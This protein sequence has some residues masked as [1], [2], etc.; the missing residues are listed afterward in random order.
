MPRL[1]KG[2]EATRDF[3]DQVGWKRQDGILN[4]VRMFNW[5]E[6]PIHRQLE[7]LRRDRVLH[8]IE[9]GSWLVELGCGGT[10]SAYLADKCSKFTGVDFS[11]VGLAEAA[12]ALKK[13]G[14]E[15]E[16]VES[17]IT[18]LPFEDNKFDVA[19]SKHVIAHIDTV[20]GQIAMLSE[21]MRVVKPGGLLILITGNPFPL[22]FPYRLT[23]R[24]LAIT[25]GLNWLL[26][27]L[28]TKP[29]LPSKPMTLGW[30]KRQLEKCGEVTITGFEVPNW[31]F[32]RLVPAETTRV[33]SLV[34][35]FILWLERYH[36]KSA[37]RL[38][39]NVLILVKKK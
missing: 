20:V 19:Y 29:P 26:N 33:G 18:S 16:L 21:A 6:G 1:N 27:K 15:F 32:D 3:Y 28:R 11:V 39:C 23:R 14:V 12:N 38:G 7:I 24:L 30:M 9:S 35:R 13:T 10:P 4:D 34:W 17:D 25:P 36:P 8:L 5:Q 31:E 2:T 22:L 37:T